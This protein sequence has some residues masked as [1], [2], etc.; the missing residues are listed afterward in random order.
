V[1]DADHR[2]FEEDLAAYLLGALGDDEARAFELH[3]HSCASCQAEERWLRG[4]VDVLPSSIEQLEPPPQLRARLMEKVH[5]EAAGSQAATAERA[6]KRRSG[7]FGRGWSFALR[8]AVA[9]ATIAIVVA[10]VAGYVIGNGGSGAGSSTVAA[11][12]TPQ[13]PQARATIVRTG[14][15]AVLRVQRLAALEPRHVY[16]VWLVRAGSTTPE[17]SSLFAVRRD[18]TGEAGMSDLD[19]VRQVMVTSEPEGGSPAPTSKP[20]LTVAL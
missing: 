7:G 11:R 13:Q 17:P 19:D 4:A 10:G 16:E 1:N 2:H 20:V 14:D 5:E 12:P 18:G 9:L 15:A 3:L 6:P 8:P